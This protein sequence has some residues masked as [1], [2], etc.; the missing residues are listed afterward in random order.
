MAKKQALSKHSRA[1]RRATS[2]DIDTDKSLKEVV[3]PKATK[4]R[5]SILAAH[6]SAGVTKKQKPSRRNNMTAKARKR[7]ERGLEMAE[8]VI[9]RTSKKKQKSFARSRNIQERAKAWED[10]NKDAVDEEAQADEAAGSRNRFEGVGDAGEGGEWETDEEVDMAAGETTVP[11]ATVPQETEL[12][13]D[14][15][16]VI[17]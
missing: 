5:P 6:Q 12:R 9:E 16:D 10:I 1:A 14:D 13:D 7:H 2:L 8:A 4:H 17:L 11:D 15:D 3:P